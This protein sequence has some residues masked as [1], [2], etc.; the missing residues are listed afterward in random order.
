[1]I[2]GR[3]NPKG[4]V[5]LFRQCS[6]HSEGYFWLMCISVVARKTQFAETTDPI[7]CKRCLGLKEVKDV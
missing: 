7:D 1:M 5:H 6:E 4:K 2:H 3:L